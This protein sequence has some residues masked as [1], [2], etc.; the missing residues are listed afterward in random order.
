MLMKLE[1]KRTKAV[2]PF[3]AVR[4]QKFLRFFSFQF[5]AFYDNECYK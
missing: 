5:A 2:M 1:Q 3:F 4:E